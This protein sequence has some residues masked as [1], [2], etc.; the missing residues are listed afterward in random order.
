MRNEKGCTMLA[1]NITNAGS[2]KLIGKFPSLK[3]RRI[4]W[5]E[6]LLE[7][8]YLYLLELD[9][10]VISYEE[11]PLQ[12]YYFLEGKKRRY[13]P[14][15]LI[16]RKYGKQIVEVKP[17]KK[18]IEPSNITLFRIADE[19]CRR[20]GYEFH[21]ATD[22]VIRS[23][24]RL[25]IAKFLYKYAR[26]PLLPQHQIYCHELFVRRQEILLGEII[27]FF[28]ARAIGQQ[29]VFALIF[30]GVLS[31]NLTETLTPSSIVRL[32][33]QGPPARKDS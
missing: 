2:T 16:Q 18:A 14:D 26:T 27:K 32:P 33:V 8:D 23:Q 22:A 21:V 9:P 13:T 12:I 25:N 30:H 29:V 28:A 6:S 1:R 19:I 10:G 17:M 24:P 3:M 5:Y 31:I 4:V 20:E 11:Q 7:R 15:L